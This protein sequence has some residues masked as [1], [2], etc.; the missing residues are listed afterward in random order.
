MSCSCWKSCWISLRFQTPSKYHS[1]M[2]ACVRDST[3]VSEISFNSFAS[4]MKNANVIR[5]EIK[6]QHTTQIL[7]PVVIAIFTHG[8]DEN[9]QFA[10]PMSFQCNFDSFNTFILNCNLL[11]VFSH[12]FWPITNVSLDWIR[13]EWFHSYISIGLQWDFQQIMTSISWRRSYTTFAIQKLS[14]KRNDMRQVTRDKT[15]KQ[16]HQK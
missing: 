14:I 1:S 9:C 10:I 3:N 15:R 2:T 5:M 12:L 4:K 16:A 11:S 7:W 13:L 8:D 6:K